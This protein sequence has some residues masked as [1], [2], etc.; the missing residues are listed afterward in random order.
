[1][2]QKK[3]KWKALWLLHIH[4][5]LS[6]FFSVSFKKKNATNKLELVDKLG[7]CELEQNCLV[8]SYFLQSKKERLHARGTLMLTKKEKDKS[9]NLNDLSH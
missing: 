6:N 7:M 8:Y 3:I 5:L 2:S 4:Q 9:V 1:M